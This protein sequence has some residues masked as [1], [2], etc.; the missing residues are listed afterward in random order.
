MPR[1]PFRLHFPNAMKD[2]RPA[3]MVLWSLGVVVACW[4]ASPVQ[5]AN[6]TAPPNILWHNK[7]TAA[8]RVWIMNGSNF[9]SEV[10]LPAT[11]DDLG[12]KVIGTADFNGDG[13]PDILWQNQITGQ[14]AV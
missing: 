4:I 14:N 10:A 12:W 1:R 7:T 3:E 8:N 11:S 13:E 5:A 9:A 2:H 6:N